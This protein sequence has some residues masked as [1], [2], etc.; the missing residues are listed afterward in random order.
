LKAEEM[1]KFTVLIED[2]MDHLRLLSCSAC[3]GGRAD[4][5]GPLLGAAG[6]GR[7]GAAQITMLKKLDLLLVMWCIC[8]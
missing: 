2:V 1:G 3:S 8:T 6:E 7:G 5:E 4:R